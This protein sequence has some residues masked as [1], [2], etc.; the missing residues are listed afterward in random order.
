M[1]R[2]AIEIEN[3]SPAEAIMAYRKMVL[4]PVAIGQSSISISESTVAPQLWGR[5][6]PPIAK[7]VPVLGL[8][9]TRADITQ[10]NLWVWQ[11]YLDGYRGREIAQRNNLSNGRAANNL[12]YRLRKQYGVK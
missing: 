10:R 3:A 9:A 1:V 5:W 12:I 2:V 4:Q 11:D 7:A 8:S 6:A